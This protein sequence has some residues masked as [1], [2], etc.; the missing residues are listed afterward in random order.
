M[1]EFCSFAHP[2]F[3]GLNPTHEILDCFEAILR[4]LGVLY[5]RRGSGKHLLPWRSRDKYRRELE[6]EEQ[7]SSNICLN[8]IINIIHKST[9]AQCGINRLIWRPCFHPWVC[10]CFYT[11]S[12]LVI[13]TLIV[14]SHCDFHL[15][16][17]RFLFFYACIIIFIFAYL[18][19][20]V[21]IVCSITLFQNAL[22]SAVLDKHYC[23]CKFL[24]DVNL[25]N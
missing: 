8:E 17:Y 15:P 5:G 19:N 13:R 7:S 6:G 2:L 3:L 24:L 9:Q 20:I 11:M 16:C 21:F 4:D 10:W 22:K 18:L 1:E 12:S 23:R 25:N 14:W